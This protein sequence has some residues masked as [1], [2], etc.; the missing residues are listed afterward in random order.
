MNR[1][2]VILSVLVL[3]TI[4]ALLLAGAAVA[5]WPRL[6]RNPNP[7]TPAKGEDLLSIEVPINTLKAVYANHRAGG[8]GFT[9]NDEYYFYYIQASDETARTLATSALLADFQRA[10][11]VQLLHE[12]HGLH[13]RVTNLLLFYGERQIPEDLQRQRQSRRSDAAPK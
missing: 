4:E 1:L 12:R 5:V 7:P 10:S 8:V 11:T 9:L 3:I 13:R 6:N 2:L